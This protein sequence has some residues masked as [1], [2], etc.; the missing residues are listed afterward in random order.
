[1][2]A[3][4][5]LWLIF[6]IIL[7][8]LFALDLRDGKTT[9]PTVADREREPKLFWLSVASCIALIGICLFFAFRT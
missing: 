3:G 5:L 4:Q 8:G 7:G 9:Y 2:T 1:M 6:A